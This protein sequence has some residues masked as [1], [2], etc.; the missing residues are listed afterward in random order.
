MQRILPDD[1]VQRIIDF[2]SVKDATQECHQLWREYYLANETVKRQLAL[3]PFINSVDNILHSERYQGLTISMQTRLCEIW[4][5]IVQ[6]T[7]EKSIKAQ[8]I[9]IEW[10]DAKAV[11]EAA[12]RKV[13]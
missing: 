6:D 12:L 3:S 4:K 9:L 1:I 2:K 10:I 13:A 11:C 8:I 7:L 5:T